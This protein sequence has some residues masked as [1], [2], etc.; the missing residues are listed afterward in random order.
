MDGAGD[1]GRLESGLAKQGSDKSAKA[2]PREAAGRAQAGRSLA[3]QGSALVRVF[4]ASGAG[5]GHGHLAHVHHNSK[6]LP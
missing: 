3:A 4:E 1:G 6:N 5:L 2:M